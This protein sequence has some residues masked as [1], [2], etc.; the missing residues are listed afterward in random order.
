MF[1]WIWHT[2][3]IVRGNED[4]MQPQQVTTSKDNNVPDDNRQRKLQWK[5][6]TKEEQQ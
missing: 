2:A 1:L 6:N 3:T 4:H 5:C